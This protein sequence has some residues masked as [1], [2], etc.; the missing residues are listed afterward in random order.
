MMAKQGH[1]LP[2]GLTTFMSIPSF[3]VNSYRADLAS[4]VF[5]RVVGTWFVFAFWASMLI[6]M[7]KR[8]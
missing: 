4:I 7:G 3:L 6:K 2:L 5:S 1:I 8:G